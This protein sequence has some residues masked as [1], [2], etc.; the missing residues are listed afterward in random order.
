M[1][2]KHYIIL[3]KVMHKQLMKARNKSVE[4]HEHTL[5]TIQALCDTLALENDHFDR[6]IFTN[7]CII[8]G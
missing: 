8:G 2:K 3:A 5:D 4:T 1:S 6:I 7:A